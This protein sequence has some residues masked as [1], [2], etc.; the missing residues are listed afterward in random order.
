MTQYN[1]LNVKLSNSQLNK[2]KSAIKN[3][4]DVVLRLSLNM[5]GNHNDETNFPHEL[6]LTNRQ[7][8]NLHKTFDNNSSADI[9]LSK[10]QLSEMIQSGGFLGRLPGPLF[11]KR[12]TLIK[13]VIKPL[14]K[15][16]LIPLG[17]TETASTA[18]G[19]IHKKILGSRCYDPRAIGSG[20]TTLIISNDEM[21]DI[22]KI[23]KSLEGSGLLLKGVS[24]TIQNEVKEQKGGFLSI[25][26]GTL[27]ASL[28]VSMLAGKGKNRA[29][30]GFIRAGYGSKKRSF[31]TTHPLTNFEIQKYYQN[32]TRFN[33]VYSRDNVPDKIKDGAYVINLDE[34]SD[35]GTHW[36]ALY[37][38]NNNVTYLDSF[39]VE[40]T[41]KEIK[42]FINKSTIVTNIFRIQA[43]NSVMS[44]YFSLDLLILCLR[45]RP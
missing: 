30:E 18:D 5:I 6:L 39:G 37:A 23:V 9:T 8:T 29:G 38:L 10:T 16:V 17:L 34:Y 43:Y 1:S 40:H 11:K 15:S 24:E 4:T 45:I 20:T 3:E 13:N 25:V 33:G 32:E 12:L 2:L 41:P 35:I 44:G 14:A 26:L 31:N 22:I 21:E 19:R 42:K 36:I 28:L 27:G 7:V